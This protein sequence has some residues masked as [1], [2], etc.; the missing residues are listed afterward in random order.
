MEIRFDGKIAL[1]TG[2]S[3]GIGLG[4]CEGLA[5]DGARLG[6]AAR[7]ADALEEAAARIKKEFGSETL[8]VAT[9]MGRPDEVSRLVDVCGKHFGRIDI[10]I[11][12]AGDVPSAPPMQTTEAEWEN[13]ITVKLLGYI[14]CARAVVPYMKQKGGS[15]VHIVSISSREGLGASGAPGVVNSALLN[16]NKTMADELAP[17]GIRVNVINPGFTDTGRMQRHTLA[18]AEARGITQDALK[19]GIL[20]QIPL[21]RFGRP[22][23][24]SN[25]VRF[26]GSDAASYITGSV[27]NVDGGFSRSIF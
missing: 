23:D 13:G 4:I 3:R 9:D 15:I 14:R 5:A 12:C 19:D 17:L 6:M 25:M 22:T 18:M 7:G 20:R 10:L 11:N 27:F 21:G 16:L 24:I 2:A 1:V 8:A 26:L